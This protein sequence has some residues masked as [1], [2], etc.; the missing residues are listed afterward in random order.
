MIQNYSSD[1]AFIIF[2]G[3]LLRYVTFFLRNILSGACPCSF[4]LLMLHFSNQIFTFL[5]VLFHFV[6]SILVLRLIVQLVLKVPFITHMPS[7]LKKRNILLKLHCYFN[8]QLF[9]SLLYI[10][11]PVHGYSNVVIYEGFNE[12]IKIST[13]RQEIM[14]IRAGNDCVTYSLQLSIS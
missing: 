1:Y 5:K 8:L 6:L 9:K 10:E 14:I 11:K 3:I 13:L 2:I 7:S 4:V 12:I